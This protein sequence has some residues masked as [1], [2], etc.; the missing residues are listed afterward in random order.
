MRKVISD[1]VWDIFHIVEKIMENKEA[2]ELLFRARLIVEPNAVIPGFNDGSVRRSVALLK[3]D[4]GTQV[5][6]ARPKSADIEPPP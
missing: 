6:L 5:G 3:S 1:A 2:R 4:E